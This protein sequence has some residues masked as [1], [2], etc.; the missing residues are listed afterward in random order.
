M[1]VILGFTIGYT[2]LFSY[3]LWAYWLPCVRKISLPLV[4]GTPRTH[5][6]PDCHHVISG[7]YLC[8]N[9]L[10]SKAAGSSYGISYSWRKSLGC[11]ITKCHKVGRLCHRYE[12][13]SHSFLPPMVAE[14]KILSVLCICLPV[15]MSVCLRALLRLN[16]VNHLTYNLGGWPWPQ[17][18][19]HWRSW[20]KGQGQSLKF[21]FS[22]YCPKR[23]SLWPLTL[24]SRSRSKVRFEGHRSKSPRSMSL[25]GTRSEIKVTK[26][27]VK[28]QVWRSR[29]QRTRSKLFVGV[30]SPHPPPAICGRFNKRVFSFICI[31]ILSKEL[32]ALHNCQH[33]HSW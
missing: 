14:E 12:T 9:V 5:H 7:S 16:H 6:L 19:S 23:R 24:S 21:C 33:F 30:F 32:G 15:C 27:K 20:V 17:L 8:E 31:F 3:P 2:D 4:D 1:L 29:S 26:G 11:R 13:L 28:N 22:V 18:E 25:S 10:S